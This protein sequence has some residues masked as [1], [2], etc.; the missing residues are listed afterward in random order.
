MVTFVAETPNI[1]NSFRLRMAM[2]VSMASTLIDALLRRSL[3]GIFVF[4][5]MTDL[6]L[7]RAEVR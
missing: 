3:N 5:R 6:D 1:D 7:D 4:I 2:T